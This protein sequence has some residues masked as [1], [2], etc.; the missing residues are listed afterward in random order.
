[1]S[2]GCWAFHGPSLGSF[3]F[4]FFHEGNE[5]YVALSSP[6]G[7]IMTE[8]LAITAHIIRRFFEDH[9]ELSDLAQEFSV[10]FRPHLSIRP[11]PDT[12]KTM[13]RHI[14]EKLEKIDVQK[15]QDLRWLLEELEER[16]RREE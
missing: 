6:L 1:M 7:T 16:E 3:D 13:L 4:H 15:A 10:L 5:S 9:A 2:G 11:A 12:L 14:L 8:D